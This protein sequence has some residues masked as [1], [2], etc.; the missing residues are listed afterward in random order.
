M[1]SVTLTDHSLA[2]SV[3]AL[4][5]YD[6]VTATEGCGPLMFEMSVQQ[7]RIQLTD[8]YLSPLWDSTYMSTVVL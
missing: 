4:T 1:Y 6:N 7:Y 2:V 3:K 8:I 5:H